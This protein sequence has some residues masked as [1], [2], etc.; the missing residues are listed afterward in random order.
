MFL[1][2]ELPSIPVP[3]S[4]QR[5]TIFSPH[6]L[7]PE[8]HRWKCW[9]LR[10]QVISNFLIIF[11]APLPQLHNCTDFISGILFL[12]LCG[13]TNAFSVCLSF[14][15]AGYLSMHSALSSQSSVD[16]ELSTSDDSIS[17][18]YKLQDLTDVQVMARLQE[19]SMW[20]QSP[21]CYAFKIVE[22]CRWI[23]TVFLSPI[24]KLFSRSL[25]MFVICRGFL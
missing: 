19:E 18:G 3:P 23:P 22:E 11:L 13:D 6:T 24:K 9:A 4:G 14:P 15:A 2:S 5:S 25:E 17:M 1:N 10:S 20:Q 8:D 21:L 12:V 7:P 16:S